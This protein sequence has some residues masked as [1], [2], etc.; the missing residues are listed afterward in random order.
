MPEGDTLYRTASVLRRLLAGRAVRAARGRPGGPSLGRLVGRQILAVE[1]RGKHLLMGF[2][3]GTDGAPALTLHTHLGLHGSWHRYR[4]GEPWRGGRQRAVAVLETDTS[5]AVCFDAPTVELIET[6]ALPL[7]PVLAALGP[8]LLAAVPDTSAALGRLADPARAA[9]PI[10]EALLD[11][12][13]LAGL[14]NV[15]RSE[16]CFVERVDPWTPVRALPAGTLE[17][18][19]ETGARLLLANRDD[20]RRTTVPDAIGGPAGTDLSRRRSA[21]LWVYGRAGRP[22]HRCGALIRSATA[23]PLA[24]RVYWCPACQASGPGGRAEASESARSGAARD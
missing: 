24:R 2:A 6:R 7:H 20:P 5:V 13:A 18:L 12:T 8:D 1:A 23:G 11:Q 15:Y 10:G 3:A 14:G 21:R 22:C 9:M 19:V 16:V 4:P 17:R